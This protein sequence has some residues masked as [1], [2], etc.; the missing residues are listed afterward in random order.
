MNIMLTRTCSLHCSYCFAQGAMQYEPVQQAQIPLENLERICRF[1][2][3]GGLDRVNLLGGEPTLH[4]NFREAVTIALDHI[5]NVH[6]VTNGLWSPRVRSVLADLPPHRIFLLINLNPPEV[7]GAAKYAAF[8]K[9]L[10]YVAEWPNV[11]FA[12][13]ID[14]RE[15]DYSRVLDLATRFGIRQL[16]WSLSYP[17]ASDASTYTLP[18]QSYPETTARLVEFLIRARSLGITA[19]SDCGV[20]NCAFTDEQI[21]RLYKHGI[22][23]ELGLCSPILDVGIDLQVYHCFPLHDVFRRSLDRFGSLREMR[24]YFEVNAGQLK[25]RSYP[26]QACTTCE[27]RIERR[28]SGGCLAASI[29][30]EDVDAGSLQDLT[31]PAVFTSLPARISADTTIRPSGQTW[32]VQT[33]RSDITSGPMAI[34]NAS[35]TYLEL[36]RRTRTPAEAMAAFAREAGV[37]VDRARTGLTELTRHLIMNHH[38]VIEP[39]IP[40]H[41]H[42]LLPI[43]DSG[44]V[45]A[46]Q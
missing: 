4:T 24:Q 34:D 16:R 32:I 37:P 21:G 25:W 23:P 18:V 3:T 19:A 39:E 27:Y 26:M 29:I 33:H 5:S 7:F 38:V 6:I 42:P 40:R 20:P 30:A 31:D 1:M 9:N 2:A 41:N 36:F 22:A 45:P 8:L 28:C 10:E 15:Y 12:I 17:I 43:L 35:R 11:A 13:N 14:R 44:S 46:A